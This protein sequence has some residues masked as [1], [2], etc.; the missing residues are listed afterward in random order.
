M[1]GVVGPPGDQVQSNRFSF[2]YVMKPSNGISMRRLVI[3][4]ESRGVKDE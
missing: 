2:T 4:E 3:G 1:H